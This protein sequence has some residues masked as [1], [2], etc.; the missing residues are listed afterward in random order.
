LTNLPEE[1]DQETLE[2]I[3]KSHIGPNDKIELIHIDDRIRIAI[4]HLNSKEAKDSLLKK[5]NFV[6]VSKFQIE[7]EKKILIRNSSS[8]IFVH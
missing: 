8:L 3:V 1:I 5:G 7:K 6:V 4:L 2:S